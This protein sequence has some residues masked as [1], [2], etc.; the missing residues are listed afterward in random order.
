MTLFEAQGQHGV[1]IELDVVRRLH[2]DR[3]RV[4]VARIH[5]F[6]LRHQPGFVEVRVL[7]DI[8]SQSPPQLMGE[9]IG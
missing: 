2:L 5:F 8:G 4:E 3:F 7:P 6:R 9:A 1:A